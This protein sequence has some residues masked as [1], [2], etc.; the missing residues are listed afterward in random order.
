MSFRQALQ[1]VHSL[2]DDGAITDYAI[3]GA[4]ALVFWSEPVA[5]YDLDVFVIL[6]STGGQLISLAPVY[7]WAASRGYP[8]EQ[9]HIIVEGVPVQLIPA[10]DDLAEEAI[11]Q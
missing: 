2:K 1:A 10:H 4:T 9:E 5:T 7:E 3:G 11:G 8:A 6:S